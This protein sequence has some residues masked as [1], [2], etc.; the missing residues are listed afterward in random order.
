MTLVVSKYL[1]ENAVVLDTIYENEIRN[2]YL[3]HE[4]FLAITIIIGK[5]IAF[6]SPKRSRCKGFVDL[7][8]NIGKH[9][10]V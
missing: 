4:Y 9:G 8:D 10:V 1:G 6:C 2:F 3:R 5:C 7:H